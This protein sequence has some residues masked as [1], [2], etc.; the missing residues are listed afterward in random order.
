MSGSLPNFTCSANITGQS[1]G[2]NLTVNMRATSGGGIGTATSIART[3]DA[4]TPTTTDNAPAGWQNA[5]QTVT[6][7]PGDSGSGLASTEYCVDTA[8][9]C[10]PGTAGTSVS[11]TQGAG[12]AGTQYVRYRSTDNLS[13]VETTRS[14]TVQIDKSAPS[15][16]SLSVT[17]GNTQNSLSWTTASDTGSGLRSGTIYDVRY[18]AGGTAPTC[19]SGTSIYT[20][21]NLTYPH[22][23]LSNGTTYSYR[24]CAY[25]SVNNVS[26][27]TFGSGTPALVNTVPN[28]P[29]GASL[30]QYQNDGTTPVT[31]GAFTNSVSPVIK[32]TITD[33]DGDSVQLEVEIRPVAGAF[34]NTPNCTSGP[35]VA[36]GTTAEATCGPLADGL[37]KWQARA[38][39]SVGD[40]SGWVQY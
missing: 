33:P 38:K 19:A 27:G 9:S 10:T 2:A 39:D 28:T 20:G 34:T 21:D 16:G 1:D 35:L 17:P 14:A 30:I 23:G 37:Y 40:T 4:A 36:S 24:V 29:P 15:D 7:T 5:N 11:V 3:V 26:T 12:T 32:A 25:D 8:N 18:L 31:T 22:T 6:L 13:N